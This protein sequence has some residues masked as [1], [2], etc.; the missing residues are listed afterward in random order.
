MSKRIVEIS[1]SVLGA[2]LMRLGEEIRMVEAKIIT[3]NNFLCQSIF[4]KAQ[5]K[6]PPSLL[7]FQWNRITII[8]LF[9]RFYLHTIFHS[10]VVKML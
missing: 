3:I 4:K 9:I 7:V 5:N 1:P 6:L 10:V 2:D 8:C